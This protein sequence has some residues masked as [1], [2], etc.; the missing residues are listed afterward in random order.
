M[1]SLIDAGPRAPADLSERLRE[2]ADAVDRGEI[3]AA[4]IATAGKEFEFHFSGSLRECLELATLLQS[5]S[6]ER[7]ST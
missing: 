3:V 2:I 6:V 1:L 4:V 7:Y 5:R